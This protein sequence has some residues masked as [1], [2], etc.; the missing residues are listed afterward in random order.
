MIG[1]IV[2]LDSLKQEVMKVD[3]E[4]IDAL[5]KRIGAKKVW[6][7]DG[8]YRI[9][10]KT[11]RKKELA[12]L[13]TDP[14]GGSIVHPQITIEKIDEKWVATQLIDLHVTPIQNIVRDELT[15][16]FLDHA[17]MDLVTKFQAIDPHE[18]TQI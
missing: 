10:T 1:A 3:L 6:Y 11:D 17:L 8:Y 14:C 7:K 16:T 18:N 15:A 12:Y 9:R 13:V 2:R 5:E 4:Q